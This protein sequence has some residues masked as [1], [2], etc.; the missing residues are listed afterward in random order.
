VYLIIAFIFEVFHMYTCHIPEDVDDNQFKLIHMAAGVYKLIYSYPLA[1][2][3]PF[4]KLG[5][6]V[7]ADRFG[8]DDDATQLAL[9]LALAILLPDEIE[10]EYS[11]E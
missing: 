8:G 3:D 6:G 9:L 7:L 10:A 4:L 11:M 1:V 2:L 5:K